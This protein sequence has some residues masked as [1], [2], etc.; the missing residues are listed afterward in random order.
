MRDML[1][2]ALGVWVRGLPVTDPFWTQ[3][4]THI[5][6]TWEGFPSPSSFHLRIELVGGVLTAVFTALS[7]S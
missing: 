6:W 5:G 1:F 4:N 2:L 3:E 7:Y